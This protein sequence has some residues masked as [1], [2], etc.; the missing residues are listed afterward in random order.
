MGNDFVYGSTVIYT[1]DS[2]YELQGNTTALCQADCQWN[3]ITP[4]CIVTCG[5]LRAPLNGHSIG[6]D[7]VFGSIV[8]FLCDTGY[9]MIF[10]GLN[11]T[12]SGR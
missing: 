3:I 5:D 10:K 6:Y 12:I 8:T 1:C 2:G 7:F 9:D 11:S 4:T